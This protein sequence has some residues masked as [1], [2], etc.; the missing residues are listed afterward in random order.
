MERGHLPTSLSIVGGGRLGTGLGRLWAARGSLRVQDVLCRSL[1]AAHRAVDRIGAGRAVAGYEDLR[2]ADLF[3]IATPDGAIAASAAR[4]V[5]GGCVDESSTV[6]HCSGAE[7]SELLEAARRRGAATASAHPLMTFSELPMSAGAFAGT[8]C[9]IEGDPRARGLLGRLFEQIG[10]TVV[11]SSTEHK[12]LYHAAAV[13]ASNYVVALLQAAVETHELLGIPPQVSREMIAPL[14]RRSVDT[15]LAAGPRAAMTGP[16]VR[17]D[18]AL[19]QRQF[20]AL[21]ASEPRIAGLYRALAVHTA[22]VAQ[23]PSPFPPADD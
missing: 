22:R 14:V 6:F 15:A 12:L 3:L 20:T 7:S 11:A 17:G 23:V 10:A 2:R 19:V 16:I 4:L 1:D 8:Y 5:A 18:A 13:F 9:A 21:L